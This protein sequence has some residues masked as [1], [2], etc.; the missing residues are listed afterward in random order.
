MQM[1]VEEARALEWLR[2][3][4][5]TALTDPQSLPTADLH[6]MVQEAVLA[7]NLDGPDSRRLTQR[8]LDRLNGPGV[9]T[10]YFLDS[11]VTEIMVI[12]DHVYVERHGRI[13][14]VA[15]LPSA[16][17]A[18]ELAEH[19]CQHC[20]EEYQTTHPI[21]NLTWPENGARINIVHHAV[22]PTGVAITIRKRNQERRLDLE[23]LLRAR[24]ITEE[25]ALLLIEAAR[26]KMNII[27]SGTPGSGK[28]TLLRAIAVPAI[29]THERVI[30]LEDTEELQLPLDHMMVFLGL[31]EEP[32][33]EERRKGL[34]TI[35]ELFRNALRQRPDRII[36][37]EIRGLEAFDLLQAAITAEGG[38]FSTVHLRRPDGLLE[39]LLWI[40]QYNHFNVGIEALRLTLPKAI[41]LVVQVDEDAARHRHVSRI[42]ESLPSGEWQDL[43]RWDPQTRHLLPQDALTADHMAW[44]DAHRSY[45]HQLLRQSPPPN[46]VW[47]DLLLPV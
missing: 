29:D 30:V 25:A 32:S 40:A 39:R 34:V 27:I 41:D 36:V 31:A 43:F 6:R 18:I 15:H 11:A 24:M 19:L 35:D 44:L 14:K 26:C 7:G 22:S 13:D 8:L 4:Y 10:P 28:T 16:E 42:V 9:L 5:P 33:P 20:H 23:D 37:G 21:L 12:G 3:H 17:I 38:V 2:P 47:A 1:P 46:D 45:K